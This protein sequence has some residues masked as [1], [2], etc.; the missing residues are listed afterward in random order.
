MINGILICSTLHSNVC[1]RFTRH[2][3]PC[4]NVCHTKKWTN[5]VDTKV[6][7]TLAFL[8]D[9]HDTTTWIFLDADILVNWNLIHNKLESYN[10]SNKVTVSADPCCWIGRDCS[11]TDAD[12]FYPVLESETPFINAGAYAGPVGLLR[13]LLA[14]IVFVCNSKDDQYCMT[15][16]YLNN[17]VPMTIDTDQH[18]FGSLAD[19]RAHLRNLYKGTCTCFHKGTLHVHSFPYE[20]S[21]TYFMKE[22]CEIATGSRESSVFYHGNG[23]VGKVAWRHFKTQKQSCMRHQQRARPTSQSSP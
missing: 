2:G 14:H 10:F 5:F 7:N 12:H 21:R 20:R 16:A 11:K 18:I 17:I 9:K 22:N 13:K 3:I 6:K 1:N 15:H 19:S 4:Y 23:P 8:Q